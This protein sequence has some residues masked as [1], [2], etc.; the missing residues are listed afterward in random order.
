[1]YTAP[2]CKVRTLFQKPSF[3]FRVLCFPRSLI[4]F[5]CLLTTHLW[6]SSRNKRWTKFSAE[7]GT[8]RRAG[9]D[10]KPGSATS[11]PCD[12]GRVTRRLRASVTCPVKWQ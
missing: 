3:L 12:P 8:E 1:M 9:L 5:L 6:D 7:Y 11:R 2:I 4:R 10:S